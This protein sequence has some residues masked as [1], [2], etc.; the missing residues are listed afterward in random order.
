MLEILDFLLGRISD[1]NVN[2][3]S[4]LLEVLNDLSPSDRGVELVDK[5]LV[6]II[7]SADIEIIVTNFY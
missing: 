6:I 4:I 3:F 2:N 5:N 7:V 1:D